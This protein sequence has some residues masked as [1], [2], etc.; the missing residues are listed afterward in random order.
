MVKGGVDARTFGN[1]FCSLIEEYPF[2]RDPSQRWCIVLD[3]CSIHH[4][5]ILKSLRTFFKIHFLAPYSPFLTPIEEY[6]GLVKYHYRH[7]LCEN[8]DDL[9]V[10]ILRAMQIPEKKHFH[11]LY[12]NTIEFFED[13]MKKNAIH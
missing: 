5:K 11:A 7:L 13:C 6:F 12:T 3:N 8:D 1:F 4:A 10:N 9:E 2:I